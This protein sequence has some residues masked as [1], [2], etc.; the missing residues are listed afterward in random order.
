[1]FTNLIQCFSKDKNISSIHKVEQSFDTEDINE[2]IFENKYIL[3][4]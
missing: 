2:S 3:E 1:M 4:K